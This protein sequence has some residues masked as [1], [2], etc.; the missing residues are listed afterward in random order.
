MLITFSAGD[1]IYKAQD[2]PDGA[3]LIHTGAV[4]VLSKTGFLLGTLNTGEIFGEVGELLSER[5]S[6]SARAKT[7]C[8]LMH[9]E[10]ITLEK[11]LDECDAALKGILRS[12]A[13]RLQSAD[14]NYEELWNELQIYKS[15]EPNN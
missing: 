7:N 4:E 6:V 12:L 13:L 1:F 11:K 9:I 2:K 8:T 10:A 14:K 15:I 3:F 5:R